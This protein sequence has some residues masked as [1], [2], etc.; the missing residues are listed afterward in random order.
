MIHEKI[1]TGALT[2]QDVVVAGVAPFPV[3]GQQGGGEAIG[4]RAAQAVH[5]GPDEIGRTPHPHVVALVNVVRDKQVVVAVFPNDGGAL[6]AGPSPVGLTTGGDL[7]FSSTHT[8]A[9]RAI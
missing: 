5:V 7:V 6:N 9:S 4:H 1:I 2:D 8:L 3:G